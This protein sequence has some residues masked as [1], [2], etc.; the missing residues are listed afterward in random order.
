MTPIGKPDEE[1][2]A[3][4]DIDGC[5]VA[6]AKGASRRAGRVNDYPPTHQFLW[7]RRVGHLSHFATE[8][9]S[10]ALATEVRPRLSL[11]SVDVIF[12][13]LQHP[14]RTSNY[15]CCKQPSSVPHFLRHAHA[16]PR[17]QHRNR[18]R[19]SHQRGSDGSTL[20]SK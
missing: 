1:S 16:A 17:T 6:L 20:R 19:R 18:R 9:T 11:L 8:Q 5:P 4:V 14:A 2:L 15:E 7:F 13:A 12:P 10:V 3:G